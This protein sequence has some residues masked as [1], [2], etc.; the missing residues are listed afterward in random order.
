MAE[1]AETLGTSGVDTSSTVASDEESQGETSRA[2]TNPTSSFK[3]SISNIALALLFFAA[4]IPGHTSRYN[5]HAADIIWMTGAA[6]MGIFSLVRIP[7]K[8]VTVT[9]NSIAATAGMMILPILIRPG[10]P[11][12]GL[13]N[14]AGTVLE[15]SGIIFTQLARVYLGRSFG[16]LPANRGIVSNGPF[17]LMRHPIYVGWFVLT[18]GLAFIYPKPSSFLLILATLPFMMWRIMQE[19]DLLRLDPE[20]RAYC[21]KVR[22]RLIPWVI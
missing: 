10:V 14:Q 18:L 13:L 1:G 6:L 17:R 16:L 20:Y 4:L 12:V 5:L 19:E 8:T 22:Y 11:S 2:E 9:A 21:E 15:V 7:P 3:N